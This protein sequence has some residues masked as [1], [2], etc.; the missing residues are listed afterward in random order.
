MA[1]RRILYLVVLEACLVF[2]IAYRQWLS[3]LLLMAVVGLPWL[4]LLISLPA[5]L[6]TK[7][8]ITGPV[9]IE[10]GGEL[11]TPLLY[12]CPLPL[13]PVR[14]VLLVRHSFSGL[15]E[16]FSPRQLLPTEH[17]GLLQITPTGLWVY[18]YLG[19]F[20]LP[21]K[22]PAAL[23][24]AVLPR[25]LPARLPASLDRCLSAALQPKPG[26]YAEQHELR[27][28][29]PGDALR[30]IHWKLTA[31]TG[32]LI[33]R[34][35]LQ[36]KPGSLLLRL[37]LSGDPQTLDR[38]LGRLRRLSGKLLGRGLTHRVSCQTGQGLLT[39]A[40]ENEAG[41]YEMLQQLLQAPVAEQEQPDTP[42]RCLWQLRIGGE[43]DEG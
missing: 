18:D 29:R 20:R 39:L 41:L 17:C 38:K 43:P 15:Q 21:L 32:K 25:E 30:G 3:W 4:S 34:E 19:I 5:M 9:R 40:V 6:T 23:Q 7:V 24:V 10:S 28:Y 27:L 13:P 37:S 33:Y 22:K 1:G 14:G 8:R 36:H 26:G 16:R 12:S 11:E 2:Y 42:E 35:P 31:K